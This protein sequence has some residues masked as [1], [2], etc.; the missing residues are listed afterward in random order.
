MGKQPEFACGEASRLFDIYLNRLNQ[1]HEIKDGINGINAGDA[2]DPL[3]V[4]RANLD[5]AYDAAVR[6]RR[7]YLQHCIEHGCRA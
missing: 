2:R 1:F 3:P 4:T 5:L 6:A 7:V